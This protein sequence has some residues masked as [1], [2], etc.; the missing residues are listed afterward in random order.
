MGEKDGP[1]APPLGENSGFL[2]VEG[3]N[4]GIDY[5]PSLGCCS[6]R[7]TLLGHMPVSQQGSPGKKANSLQAVLRLDSVGPWKSTASCVELANATV[8]GTGKAR[9]RIIEVEHKC[10]IH[11]SKAYF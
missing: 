7:D 11:P 4:H 9:L 5:L 10:L 3:F 6:R 8:A 1:I 2:M